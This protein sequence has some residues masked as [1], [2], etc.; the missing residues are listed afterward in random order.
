MAGVTSQV[1]PFHSDE[2]VRGRRLRSIEP[3]EEFTC[4]MTDA[5]HPGS[6]PWSWTAPLESAPADAPGG[7][8]GELGLHIE[9]PAAVGSFGGAWVEYGLIERA[10]ALARP[11]DFATLIARYGHTH[12]A[13][14]RYTASSYLGRTLGQLAKTGY[15]AYRSGPGTGRWS[16]DDEVGYYT[17]PTS[18]AAWE[19]RLT[20][21]VAGGTVDYL[22]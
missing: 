16:Y 11:D 17:A 20:W 6:R 7:L 10:Y 19:N 13:P 18:P 12:Q 15:L 5:R 8:A 4:P 21:D 3:V 14:A 22:P 1:C 9:L 2:M